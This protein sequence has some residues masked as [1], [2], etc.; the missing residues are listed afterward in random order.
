M[1]KIK[2]KGVKIFAY[3]GVNQ[4]EN[5]NGQFFFIDIKIKVNKNPALLKDNIDYTVSYSTINKL[6]INIA[7]KQT[8]KLIETLA[9]TIADQILY[10]FPYIHSVKIKVSK[11]FAPMKGDFK[12]V[13]VTVKR[14]NNQ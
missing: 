10:K 9:V 13:S 2:I 14:Y 8:Y 4:D 11:P 3:H 6:I 7:T 12:N 1:Y 5:K